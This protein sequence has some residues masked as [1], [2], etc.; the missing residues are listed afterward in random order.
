MA[1]KKRKTKVAISPRWAAAVTYRYEKGSV[2]EVFY[3]DELADL[4]DRIE[5]GPHWDTVEKIEVVRNCPQHPLL[6]VEEA[7]RL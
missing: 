1:A 2:R 5:K 6:T 7:E 4:H 3:L